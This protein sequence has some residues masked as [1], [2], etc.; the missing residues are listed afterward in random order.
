M[1]V[2]NPLPRDKATRVF[3]LT[4]AKKLA[5]PK[6]QTARRLHMNQKEKPC[7]DQTLEGSAIARWTIDPDPP[8]GSQIVEPK[9]RGRPPPQLTKQQRDAARAAWEAK[10]HASTL[11]GRP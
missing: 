4:H 7:S 9:P 1:L 5:H 10:S 3:F 8:D 11:S 2:Y 6:E